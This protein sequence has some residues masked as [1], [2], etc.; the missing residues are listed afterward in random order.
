MNHSIIYKDMGTWKV[1]CTFPCIAA[2]KSE[3]RAMAASSVHGRIILGDSK[4]AE[5]RCADWNAWI[6]ER[7]RTPEYREYLRIQSNL[8]A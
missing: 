4:S 3:A 6:D 8:H 5:A 7:R 1:A 2:A